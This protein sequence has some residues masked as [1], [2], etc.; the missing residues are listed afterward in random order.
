VATITKTDLDNIES[1]PEAKLARQL[2]ESVEQKLNFDGRWN[3]CFTS[4]A[5]MRLG[6][7]TRK[8]SDFYG[9]LNGFDQPYFNEIDWDT[10]P[11]PF[12]AAC[13]EIDHGTRALQSVFPAPSL[14]P[15][16][17]AANA[18]APDDITD[19]LQGVLTLD[20]L[21]EKYIEAAL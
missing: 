17:D 4:E 20:Q 10:V 3:S 14:K 12:L 7:L 8:E 9:R 15:V 5:V 19:F 13:C 18:T 2:Q 11:T 1:T 21:R 16:I 6:T